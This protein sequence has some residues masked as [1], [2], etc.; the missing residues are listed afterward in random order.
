MSN[1]D[2]VLHS[3]LLTQSQT[4]RRFEGF[5]YTARVR[6]T[7]HE[8][9][10]SVNRRPEPESRMQWPGTLIA[11]ARARCS[12]CPGRDEAGPAAVKAR[13]NRPLHPPGCAP[14]CNASK[15][16]PPVSSRICRHQAP[17]YFKT[18]RNSVCKNI[19]K[20]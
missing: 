7:C 10:P 8:C 3:G 18:S 11:T 6:D 15:L 2:A 13:Q 1:R 17:G 9:V 5:F 20:K 14:S 16:T 4:I 12:F 19:R